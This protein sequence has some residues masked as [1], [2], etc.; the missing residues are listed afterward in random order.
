[1][2]QMPAGV[3]SSGYYVA[4]VVPWTQI[5]TSGFEVSASY[6]QRVADVQDLNGNVVIVSAFGNQYP[7]I[8][9]S[10]DPSTGTWSR[11]TA[12]WEQIL[13]A[14]YFNGYYYLGGWGYLKRNASLASTGWT[15]VFN[16]YG[17]IYEFHVDSGVLYAI[18]KHSNGTPL[19]YKTTNGTSWD[20]LATLG[21]SRSPTCITSSPNSL[22]I[23]T[24]DN[25]VFQINKST[26]ATEGQHRPRDTSYNPTTAIQDI[27][28]VPGWNHIVVAGPAGHLWST[29]INNI[30]Y[31]WARANVPFYSPYDF[32]YQSHLST[33]N[34]KTGNKAFALDAAGNLIVHGAGGT[35]YAL[36]WRGA[37]N[38]PP[39]QEI[40][41]GT[42]YGGQ[43]S[44]VP[45]T[46]RPSNAWFGNANSK[47][48]RYFPTRGWLFIS[49][50]DV[51]SAGVKGFAYT[52][53]TTAA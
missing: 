41:L 9:H 1:M 26:G 34:G 53:V 48:I 20:T 45:F 12:P 2:P 31:Q 21:S 10:A 14:T 51:N 22:W 29:P 5:T 38:A 24:S 19:V 17:E 15:D 28:Y 27:I 13:C 47:F 8:T 16:H 11:F 6:A 43:W 49:Q 50:G 33:Y 30:W 32:A 25:Y 36:F 39:L 40:Y 7:T 18:G 4:P 35:N 42:Y 3:V 23:G 46:D 44:P 37:N 52:N